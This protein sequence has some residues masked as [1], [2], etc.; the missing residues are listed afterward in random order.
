MSEN[1]LQVP[2]AI[3]EPVLSYA[4]GSPERKALETAIKDARSKDIEIPMFIDGKEV[5]TGNLVT[6]HPPHDLQH[7]LGHYHKGDGNHVQMAIQA[8]LKAKEK[9]AA[10]PWKSRAAIFLKAASLLAGPYR[11]KMNAATMLA[12]SKNPFQAEIDSACETIDFWR[13][14][15]QFMSEIYAHQPNSDEH[16]W[17]QLEQRSLEGFVFALTPFNFTRSEERRVGKECRSRWS[18][19]H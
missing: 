19:Y 9:W 15:A 18:P 10:M 16:I 14:N 13:F 8:A 5:K 1:L 17:N 4:P 7:T 3:N 12:Q 11:Y 2:K 6:I